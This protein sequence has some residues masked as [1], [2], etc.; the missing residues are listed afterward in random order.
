[1]EMKRLQC[2]ECGRVSREDERA[3]HH[4]RRGVVVYCPDCDER[5]FGDAQA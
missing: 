1:M 3:A 4:R 2:V 5:E